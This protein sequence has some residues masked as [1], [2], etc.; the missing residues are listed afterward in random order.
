MLLLWIKKSDDI[1]QTFVII[2]YLHRS[3]RDDDCQPLVISSLSE[4]PENQ[5][6]RRR[7][8][9]HFSI[10][11]LL[12]YSKERPIPPP[13]KGCKMGIDYAIFPLCIA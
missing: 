4:M 3:E 8:N 2:F 10:P 1:R 6:H 12:I 5:E 11:I 13:L 9:E 7:N